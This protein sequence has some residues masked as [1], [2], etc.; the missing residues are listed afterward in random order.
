MARK[1]KETEAQFLRR[2]D[3]T[4]R[5]TRK[6]GGPTTDELVRAIQIRLT[7]KAAEQTAA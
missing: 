2:I 4:F 3:R 5:K 7:A 1:R 6:A